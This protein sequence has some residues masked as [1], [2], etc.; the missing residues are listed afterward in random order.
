M[1]DTNTSPT[2]E[3]TPVTTPSV[4]QQEDAILNAL[5][6]RMT[7]V[8]NG[9]KHLKVLLYSE[10]GAGKTTWTGTAPNNL[11]VD[12]EKG[13]ASLANH[14]DIVKDTVQEFE[15]KSF[16][17]MELLV[18]YLNDDHE[19]F[20]HIKTLTIDSV[21]ELHKKG[22]AEIVERDW[23]KNPISNNRYKAETDHHTENN[24]HIRRLVSSLRDLERNIILT[25]HARTVVKEGS[26]TKV[27]PDFSEKL[28]N[29][30]AGIVDIVIYVDKREINGEMKR[31]FRF[32]SNGNITAKSRIGGLPPEAVNI[33][34]DDLWEAFEKHLAQGNK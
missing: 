27:Y 13:L 17:Q 28:A 1:T 24:E 32:H 16:E 25:A 3:A 9:K 2:A 20:K 4:A 8:G 5:L 23:K 33:T 31:V 22:L 34:W 15:Y 7:S 21:S 14:P 18:K 10:P 19:A 30:I 26:P 29:T 11:I 6:G 12:V